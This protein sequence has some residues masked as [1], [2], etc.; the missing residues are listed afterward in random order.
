MKFY[1]HVDAEVEVHARNRI[2]TRPAPVPDSCLIVMKI[3]CSPELELSSGCTVFMTC[4]VD[5]SAMN[6]NGVQGYTVLITTKR[7]S[8][9]CILL[10]EE[11]R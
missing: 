11:S 9:K 7:L 4:K 2:D 6:S 8:G 3:E 10:G 1:S 5:T